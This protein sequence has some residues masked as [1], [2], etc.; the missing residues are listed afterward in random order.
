MSSQVRSSAFGYRAD[1]QSRLA[2]PHCPT[3]GGPAAVVMI[4]TRAEY[5]WNVRQAKPL[6]P[7]ICPIRLNTSSVSLVLDTHVF[8]L[9][10]CDLHAHPRGSHPLDVS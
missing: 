4:P 2:S 10:P 9:A 3:P 8:F 5:E 1:N 6:S 7:R